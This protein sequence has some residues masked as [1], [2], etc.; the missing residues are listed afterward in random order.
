MKTKWEIEFEKWE[1]EQVC[2]AAVQENGD[3]LQYVA[4][5]KWGRASVRC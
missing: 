2:L 4:E 3:A 5:A 1:S